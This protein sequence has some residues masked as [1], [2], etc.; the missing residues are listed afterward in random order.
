MLLAAPVTDSADGMAHHSHLIPCFQRRAN[1]PV[2]RLELNPV[3]EFDDVIRECA[4][5]KYW[6]LSRCV[7][8]KSRLHRLDKRVG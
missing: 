2:E 4:A 8:D 5:L 1:M 6:L 3:P 7:A